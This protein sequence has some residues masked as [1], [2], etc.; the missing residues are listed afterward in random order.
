MRAARLDAGHGGPRHAAN[1]Q[2]D[3][4]SLSSRHCTSA[5]LNARPRRP[6]ARQARQAL[7]GR[8]TR[9]ETG[10]SPSASA[11]RV[12]AHRRRTTRPGSTRT[13]TTGARSAPE[14]AGIRRRAEP[15]RSRVERAVCAVNGRAPEWSRR[16]TDK[17]TNKQK[18]T[19]TTE[20][21][22]WPRCQLSVS[23]AHGQERAPPRETMAS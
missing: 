23:R 18:H 2:L 1:W 19:R 10:A 22:G 4:S 20:V 7:G 21:G 16:L 11:G 8:S 17:Q 3:L 12:A 13:Y 15:T 5:A 14:H 9:P 6:T